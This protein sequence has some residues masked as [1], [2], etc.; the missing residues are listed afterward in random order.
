M[1]ELAKKKRSAAGPATAESMARSQREISVSEFFAKNRHLLGFDSPAKALLTTIKEAVDNSLDACEEAAILPTLRVE[2]LQLAED[3]F[4]IAV[5]DNG[6]GVPPELRDTLFYPLVSGRAGGSGLGLALAQEL[7]TRQG[8]IV[9]Y[10]SAPP[11]TVF[12][13]LFPNLQ[14]QE[15]Y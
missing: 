11:C 1:L 12:Q 15:I 3:R 13:M 9:E 4:R 5:E 8:G 14:I 10:T 6:P 2:I 7:V